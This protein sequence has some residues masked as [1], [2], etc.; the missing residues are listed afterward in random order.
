MQ[1]TVIQIL[2]PD[3]SSF[4][5]KSAVRPAAGPRPFDQLP[6][7]AA[8][9]VHKNC[10]S[11]NTAVY[12]ALA[13]TDISWY[14]PNCG[15]PNFSTS[16]FKDFEFSSSDH[17]TTQTSVSSVDSVGDFFTYRPTSDNFLPQQR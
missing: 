7:L 12:D 4:H 10:L 6:V 15:L 16:L 17:D 13:T 14:C 3:K 2:V 11:M 1:R 9:N 8:I 5:V